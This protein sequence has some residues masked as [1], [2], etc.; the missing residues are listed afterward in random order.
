M[1]ELPD[2][3]EWLTIKEVAELLGV[4]PMTVR[5]MIARLELPASRASNAPRAAWLINGPEWQRQREAD[6]IRAD[7]RRRLGGA[8]SG[9]GDKEFV[10]KLRERYPAAAE[11]VRASIDRQDRQELLERLED[12]MRSDPGVQSRLRELDEAD[13]IEAKAQELARRIREDEKVRARAREI[14]SE[15]DD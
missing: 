1:N 10:E 2:N 9:Y 11:H 6:A 7:A 5:R 14:L 13:R 8:V 4:V 3:K 12:E 15:D